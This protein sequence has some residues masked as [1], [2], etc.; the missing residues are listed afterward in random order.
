MNTVVQKK[1]PYPY[2]LDLERLQQEVS[3][4]I[5]YILDLPNKVL[6]PDDVVSEN[7]F[8]DIDNTTI[9]LK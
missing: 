4:F 5:R 7:Y 6:T 3:G 2:F 8:I 1:D 9:F